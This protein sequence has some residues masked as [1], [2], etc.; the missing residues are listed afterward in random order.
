MLTGAPPS[1]R[2]SVPPA[3]RRRVWPWAAGSILIPLLV[4]AGTL[5]G[6]RVATRDRL[7]SEVAPAPA[8]PSLAVQAIAHAPGQ[9]AHLALDTHTHTLVAQIAACQSV[10]ASAPQTAGAPACIAQ[11]NASAS[12]AFFDSA[13]GALRGVTRVSSTPAHSAALTDATH[14][15]TYLVS[16][17]GGVTIYDDATG[18]QAGGYTSQTI[19][20][21]LASTGGGTDDLALDGQFSLLYTV[22]INRFATLNALDATS[23]QVVASASLPAPSAG[24]TLG[25]QVRVDTNA[26]RVYVF[27]GNAMAPTLFAF[28]AS[29]LTPLGYWSFPGRVGGVGPLDSA[30]HTLYVGAATGDAPAELDLTHLP[31]D[32]AG[33]QVTPQQSIQDATLA[34]ARYFGVDGA[35]GAVALTTNTGL[36]ALAANMSQPY[37]KLPLVSAPAGGV[38]DTTPWLLPVDSQTGL[39]YLPGEENTIFIVNMARPTSFAAPNALTATLMARAGMAA[40]LPNTNQTPAFA[41]ARSFPLAAGK[42]QRQYFIYYSNLG[43][44]GPYGGYTSITNVKPGATAGDYTM[45]FTLAWD[46]LF[47]RQHSW[48]VELT[49]DGRTHLLGDSGDGLP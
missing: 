15:V 27:N 49:P 10:A 38:L 5:V 48:T 23:G 16:E 37:A 39:A 11:P 4:I 20:S 19:A 12:L 17:S 2:V 35:N 32:G 43:W 24:G 26:N 28:N 25:A 36:E 47:L 18:K 22:T 31:A 45:T 14:G 42:E 21:A 40:L 9:I 1:D 33:E 44:K 3:P 30:T 8:L 29:D 46:Q 34:R 7:A 13:T 41:D 6:Q